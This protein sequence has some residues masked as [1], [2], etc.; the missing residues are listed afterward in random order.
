MIGEQAPVTSENL[1]GEMLEAYRLYGIFAHED[2]VRAVVRRIGDLRPD[3][4]HAIHGSTIT[5]DALSHYSQALLDEQFAYQGVLFGR[6]IGTPAAPRT[7]ASDAVPLSLS[8]ERLANDREPRKARTRGASSGW[9]SGSRGEPT[10]VCP[11]QPA[12]APHCDATCR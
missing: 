2:P 1:A 5:G 4:I 7:S 3:W 12:W 11:I 8:G 6:P 10:V 9:A